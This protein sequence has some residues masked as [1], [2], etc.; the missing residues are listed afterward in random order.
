VQSAEVSMI[1][2]NL[3]KVTD[4]SAANQILDLMENLEDH[5]DVQHVY[6]NFDIPDT[7]LEKRNN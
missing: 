7:I 5:E 6:A 1:P 4:E 3:I 2:A